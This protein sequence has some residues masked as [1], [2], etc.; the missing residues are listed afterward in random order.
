MKTPLLCMKVNIQSG[1]RPQHSFR[2]Q[3]KQA[4]MQ[5]GFIDKRTHCILVII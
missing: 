1:D 5:K 4:L 2:R 3:G